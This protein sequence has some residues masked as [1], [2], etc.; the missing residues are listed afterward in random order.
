MLRNGPVCPLPAPKRWLMTGR[1][2]GRQCA[3]PLGAPTTT[4]GQGTVNSEVISTKLSHEEQ[5]VDFTDIHH[6]IIMLIPRRN[7]ACR[8]LDLSDIREKYSF[9][10]RASGATIK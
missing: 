10:F 9:T 3:Q 8:V 5:E 1:D 4:P 7:R 6:V 2:G